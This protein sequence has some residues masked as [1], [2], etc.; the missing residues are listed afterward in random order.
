MEVI[1]ETQ[2]LKKLTGCSSEKVLFSDFY[3]KSFRNFY[4]SVMWSGL[5]SNDVHLMQLYLAKP[6]GTIEL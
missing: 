3:V 1:W 5:P 6:F 4:I 2:C